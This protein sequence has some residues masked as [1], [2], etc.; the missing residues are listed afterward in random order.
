MGRDCVCSAEGASN[1]VVNL[2]GK[3]TH[4]GRSSGESFLMKESHPRGKPFGKLS[5]A[6]TENRKHLGVI[7][8]FFMSKF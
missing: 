1:M 5:G 6:R 8:S 2:S 7:L 4:V 3:K